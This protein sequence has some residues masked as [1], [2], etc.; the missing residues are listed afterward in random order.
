MKTTLTKERKE[1]W[2]SRIYF[3]VSH[4]IDFDINPFEDLESFLKGKVKNLTWGKD[5]KEAKQKFCSKFLL[6]LNMYDIQIPQDAVIKALENENRNNSE[7]ISEWVS[8]TVF[9]LNW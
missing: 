2:I 6:V 4:S 1:K 8:K 5:K 7:V 3:G 9:P